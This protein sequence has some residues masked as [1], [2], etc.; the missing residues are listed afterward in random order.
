MMEFESTTFSGVAVV[1]LARL[2]PASL[3]QASRMTVAVFL[4]AMAVAVTL[5]GSSRADAA[6][7]QRGQRE[8]V[9]SFNLQDANWGTGIVLSGR[10]GYLLTN[11]HE[12][13]PLVNIIWSKP[14]D[15]GSFLG[16]NLGAFY[17]YNLP[18]PRST[19]IPYAGASAWGA[20]GDLRNS[21]DFG[22]GV[23]AGVRVMLAPTAA[24]NLALYLQ[25]ER[26]KTGPDRWQRTSGVAAGVSVFF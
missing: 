5:V 14:T 7:L 16:G 1:A 19:L 17:R 8:A 15:G 12:A 20:F 2:I 21:S 13:G 3:R 10:A 26:F 18:I 11:R 4:A 6:E 24:I 25:R 9:F 23:D 22:A